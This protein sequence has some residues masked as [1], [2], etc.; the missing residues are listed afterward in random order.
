MEMPRLPSTK[1]GGAVSLKLLVSWKVGAESAPAA[2]HRSKTQTERA[3]AAFP[4]KGVAILLLFSSRSARGIFILSN[5]H[6]ARTAN[7]RDGHLC[8]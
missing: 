8:D 5:H 7:S 3:Q 4:G 1:R 2:T 6:V